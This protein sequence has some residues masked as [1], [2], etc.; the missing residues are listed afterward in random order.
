MEMIHE[1]TRGEDIAI[2]EIGLELGEIS[3]AKR[4]VVILSDGERGV[5]GVAVFSVEGVVEPDS[6]LDDRAVK[7]EER[8]ELVE[9]PSVLVLE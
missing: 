1:K 7:G 8:E 5:D 9:A 4:V 2:G 3:E 6:A